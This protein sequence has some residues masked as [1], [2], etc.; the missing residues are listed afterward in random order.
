MIK[1]LELPT[2]ALLYTT[3]LKILPSYSKALDPFLDL[4]KQERQMVPVRY[5]AACPDSH[6]VDWRG[7]TNA[8]LLA[9][10]VYDRLEK[11]STS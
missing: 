5:V 8:T 6:K 4:S 9:R 10:F 11:S 7:R 3:I 1:S 2:L